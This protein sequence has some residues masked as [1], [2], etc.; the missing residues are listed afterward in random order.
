MPTEKRIFSEK[1]LSALALAFHAFLRE[2]DSKTRKV[3]TIRIVLESALDYGLTVDQ[4]FN[5]YNWRRTTEVFLNATAKDY[6]DC[7]VNRRICINSIAEEELTDDDL[8]LLSTAYHAFYQFF[9]SKGGA[10]TT[11]H[12]SKR[13]KKVLEQFTFQNLLSEANIESL[14]G[15]DASCTDYLIA[16]SKQKEL[17]GELTQEQ[18]VR[19]E[20]NSMLEEAPE[21]VST[22]TDEEEK[23]VSDEELEAK[24]SQ[25]SNES[26]DEEEVKLIAISGQTT[27]DAEPDP[28]SDFIENMEDL[29]S[30][31][32][33]DVPNYIS[34]TDPQEYKKEALKNIIF[35]YTFDELKK[36]FDLTPNTGVLNELID[37]LVAGNVEKSN[38]TPECMDVYSYLCGDLIPAFITCAK[39]QGV[40]MDEEIAAR[41]DV[42]AE[43]W[44]MRTKGDRM[45]CKLRNLIFEH[46]NDDA[47]L[48]ECVNVLDNVLHLKGEFERK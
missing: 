25:F 28:F 5:P 48:Y 19:E 32:D 36:I 30:I 2:L 3:S 33:D 15:V 46:G 42:I 11:K 31:E 22:D 45:I 10:Y 41:H 14:T 40:E 12:A 20:E 9:R 27:G 37:N 1:E 13:L 47:D 29:K 21:P 44:E 7:L 26:S 35:K 43:S 34:F 4:I 8:S 23:T 17:P 38:M 18:T 24:L 6:V 39:M 16:V